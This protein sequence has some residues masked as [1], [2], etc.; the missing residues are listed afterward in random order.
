MGKIINFERAFGISS[1]R[2]N[3]TEMPK[4]ERVIEISRLIEIINDQ[5]IPYDISTEEATDLVN[6]AVANLKSEN[7][8][9]ESAIYSPHT[10]VEPSLSQKILYPYLAGQR[11]GNQATV[12]HSKGTIDEPC[13]IAHEFAHVEGHSSE[14][15]AQV[16]SYLALRGS[17]EPLLELCAHYD[18]LDQQTAV[19]KSNL[20]K[21]GL[22]K[23]AQKAMK[24]KV[25]DDWTLIPL[26]FTYP[27]LTLKNF[28]PRGVKRSDYNQGPTNLLYT[29]GIQID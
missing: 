14:I 20:K 11:L 1:D 26:L 15:E 5:Y 16:I 3:L 29:A 8:T 27:I 6:N 25:I 21:L 12:I 13:T 24:S 18:R 10:L 2:D 4:E 22:R 23:E 7:N 28:K 9:G 17:G 19:V